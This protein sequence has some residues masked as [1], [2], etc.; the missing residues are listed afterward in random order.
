MVRAAQ[1]ALVFA[2]AFAIAMVL[3][4]PD[5][6]DDVPG[7]MSGSHLEKIQK[8]ALC[9]ISPPAQ[10]CLRYQLQARPNSHHAPNSFQLFDLGCVYRC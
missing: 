4:T 2:C 1:I 10:R 3:I 7:V 9:A 5:P 8:L 6:T